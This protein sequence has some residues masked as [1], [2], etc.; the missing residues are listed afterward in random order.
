MT[1][2]LSFNRAEVAKTRL[3]L[4]GELAKDGGKRVYT[5]AIDVLRKTW[6]YEGIRGIQ[7]GLPPGYVYQVCHLPNPANHIDFSTDSAQ[8]IAAWIL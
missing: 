7:R 3:Q 6:K 1:L 2:F 4:Q 5:S 8:W